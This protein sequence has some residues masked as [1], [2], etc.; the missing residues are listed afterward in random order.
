MSWMYSLVIKSFS[1]VS[2]WPLTRTLSNVTS[3][4]VRVSS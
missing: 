4:T 1:P 2:F 3:D